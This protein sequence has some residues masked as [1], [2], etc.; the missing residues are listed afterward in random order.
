MKG[1]LYT[2]FY[3]WNSIVIVRYRTYVLL[4]PGLKQHC[5]SVEELKDLFS[6]PLCRSCLISSADPRPGLHEIFILLCWRFT[7][8]CLLSFN[9]FSRTLG[10]WCY[11]WFPIRV[12]LSSYLSVKTYIMKTVLFLCILW[13]VGVYNLENF[14]LK[15]R[16]HHCRWKAAKSKPKFCASGRGLHRVTPIVTWGFCFAI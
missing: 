10:G 4:W 11:R 6:W 14:S 15:W 7:G 16:R 5:P 9:L 12:L 8:T 1:I 13:L 3:R 2:H